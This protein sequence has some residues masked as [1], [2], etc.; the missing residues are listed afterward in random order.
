MVAESVGAGWQSLLSSS[1]YDPCLAENYLRFS[2]PGSVTHDMAFAEEYVQRYRQGEVTAISNIHSSDIDP[3]HIELLAQFQVQANLVVPI[4]H[5][6]QFWGLLIAHHCDAPRTWQPLEIDLLKELAMPV[7]LALRQAQL[8]Q[9]VQ[10]ELTER[11]QAEAGLRESE[12]KLRV[13]LK[14]SRMGTWDWNIQTGQISWSENLEALFGLEP[15]EFDGSFEMFAERLHPEDR[16]R[17]LA[18][19]D[20]AV[21]TGANYEIEFRILYPNGTIRWALTQGKVFYDPN[22]QPL[23]MAGIDIDITG[24]KQSEA[25]LQESEERFRQLAENID[26]VFWIKEA[27]EIRVRYVSPAYERLWGWDPQELYESQ[28]N[29]VN[30]IHPDDRESTDRAFQEKAAAGASKRWG[31]TGS[32]TTGQ[33]VN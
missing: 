16:E 15:G 30:H 11:Q 25:I 33:G 8:H 27:S 14:A 23:R 1:I 31:S 17:V 28:Q 2:R 5:D 7:S 6:D 21:A 10:Q 22:G 18:S 26:A 19:V 12:E 20:Q 9:Q 13:A 3:C 32:S 29:W 24:R 4:L